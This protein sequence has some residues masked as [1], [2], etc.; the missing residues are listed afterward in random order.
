MNGKIE[1]WKYSSNFLTHSIIT[2]ENNTQRVWVSIVKLT[3]G[4]LN[5]TKTDPSSL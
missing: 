5:I 1:T 2:D 3:G 4:D